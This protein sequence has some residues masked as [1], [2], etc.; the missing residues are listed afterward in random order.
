[1]AK[2]IAYYG[3]DWCSTLWHRIDANKKDAK[4]KCGYTPEEDGEW[5]EIDVTVWH[6]TCIACAKPNKPKG[7]KNGK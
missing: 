5:W 6:N 4:A 3:R 1:M 7:N 2:G